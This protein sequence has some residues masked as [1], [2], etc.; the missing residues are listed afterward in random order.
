MEA[1]RL[2]PTSPSPK[3]NNTQGR[4]L[5][6]AFNKHAEGGKTQKKKIEERAEDETPKG[7]QKKVSGSS[8]INSDKA[9]A[10]ATGTK[11]TGMMIDNPY[12]PKKG[13][14]SGNEEPTPTTDNQTKTNQKATTKISYAKAANSPQATIVT[15]QKIKETYDSFFEVSF[16]IDS[17]Q[18]DP[19]MQAVILQMREKLKAILL[20]AKE[21]DRKAK[22]NA[23]NNEDDLPTITKVEDI[24]FHPAQLK[25][26]M[27][28]HRR[29]TQL[30]T[31]NNN[32]WR[33]R[34]TT[35]IPRQEFLHYWGLTKREFTKV[36]Y[37]TLRDAPLQDI[38]YHAVGYFLNSSDGQLTAELEEGLCKELGFKIGIDYRPAALDKR[39]ADE[40][41]KAAKKQSK[42]ALAYE[43]NRT[44]FKHAPFAQQVYAPTRQQAHQAAVA[45]SKAYGTPGKDGQYPRLPDG[46]RMRFVAASIYLDMQGRATAASLFP[47]QVRFQTSEVTAT[48]PVKDP[49]QRFEQHNN[50]TMQQ[51]ILDLKDPDMG[52]EPFFR[53]LRKKF[54]WNYK[55]QEYE[56]SIHGQMFNRS[57]E[58]LKNLKNILTEKYGHEVGD[59]IAYMDVEDGKQDLMSR[60]GGMSGITLSTEDRYLNGPAQF[61]IEGLE[62]VKIGKEETLKDIRQ[63]QDDTNTMNLRSTA[64]SDMTGQTGLTVPDPPE[65]MTM[66]ERS[67]TRH[68]SARVSVDTH[69]TSKN[70]TNN[71]QT[72]EPPSSKRND[73]NTWITKGGAA[74]A[75]ALAKRLASALDPREE[76]D[77]NP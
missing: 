46:S 15:H 76:G 45:M 51:L 59:A 61:I 56:V 48:I 23:W 29:T 52:D 58:V 54:H 49:Q 36:E 18:V 32:G 35:K 68:I 47:Q 7:K 12:T 60:D 3:R 69:H 1:G 39:A 14:E 62:N 25:A 67:D 53:H 73:S 41:W 72:G 71:E 6:E 21:V 63:E 64:G 75:T 34:I 37:I 42:E 40:L 4:A 30:K 44:F 9:E 50:K 31:G 74:A 70:A 27:T 65:N 22:I 24:P 11:S 43:R 8:S 2:T 33:V 5:F 55:T 17:I 38:T 77:H 28:N 57:I 10:R 13:A 19:P 16:K 20:R 66:D 26:Y